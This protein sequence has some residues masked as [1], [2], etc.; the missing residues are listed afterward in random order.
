MHY[1]TDL[2]FLKN[3]DSTLPIF[4]LNPT[5]KSD[6]LKKI[7]SGLSNEPHRG[8]GY[9]FIGPDQDQPNYIHFIHN[10]SLLNKRLQDILL[11]DFNYPLNFEIQHIHVEDHLIIQIQI[12]ELPYFLKPL[13]FYSDNLKIEAYR[14]NGTKVY[15]CD[16]DDYSLFKLELGF[17]E[18]YPIKHATIYDIDKASLAKLYNQKT[19]KNTPEN[20]LNVLYKWLISNNLAIF[21]NQKIHLTM[22]GVILLANSQ[23]LQSFFP[24]YGIKISYKSYNPKTFNYDTKFLNIFE[25]IMNLPSSVLENIIF[26]SPFFKNEFIDKNLKSFY[27]DLLVYLLT[28]LI[29][30][31]NYHLNKQI[32]IELEHHRIKIN[33]P[34]IIDLLSTN[35]FNFNVQPNPYLENLLDFNIPY[36][37]K[38][39]ETTYKDFF[40]VNLLPA[41]NYKN[42]YITNE[43]IVTLTLP[44]IFNYNYSL[45]QSNLQINPPLINTICHVNDDESFLE[46]HGGVEF[47]M[48]SY[49]NVLMLN[50]FKSNLRLLG[51]NNFY[52]YDKKLIALNDFDMSEWSSRLFFNWV[53]I[54]NHYSFYLNESLSKG[55]N[56]NI[57]KKNAIINLSNFS[58]VFFTRLLQ[59]I[60]TIDI[61]YFYINHQNNIQLDQFV[62]LQQYTQYK[63]QIETIPKELELFL[64]NLKTQ[65]S[66]N[67]FYILSLLY[68][69]N[70]KPQTLYHLSIYLEKSPK[71]ILIN[72][73]KPLRT[74]GYLGFT[75]KNV[76]N[77]PNQAYKTIKIKIKKSDVHIFN[78]EP[79]DASH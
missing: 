49:H 54:L 43:C 77:H 79:N 22:L 40:L 12:F 76:S 2:D 29:L 32:S 53:P 4:Y 31:R 23:F 20:I 63:S 64:K 58:D 13:K 61:K 75:K 18:I 46:L 62:T 55:S 15:L 59:S 33:C 70:W 8:G 3:I 5:F 37:L 38:Y 72:F 21:S 60:K 45:V 47:K 39:L 68:I 9:I 57:F 69:C 24:Q 51:F 10:Q 1:L 74:K 36:Q 30:K 35:N 71:Y 11:N 14:L 28:Y 16:R 78:A 34:G 66:K 42:N 25:N 44:K 17:W 19:H 6:L 48:V 7:V 56:N 73:V 27:K 41:L 52:Q 65:V 50:K 67:Y 26:F